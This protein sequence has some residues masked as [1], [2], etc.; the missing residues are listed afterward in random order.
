MIY[1]IEMF[2]A[3]VFRGLQFG[4]L[5][6]RGDSFFKGFGFCSRNGGLICLVDCIFFEFFMIYLCFSKNFLFEFDSF[7]FKQRI[8]GSFP[9]FVRGEMFRYY[10]RLAENWDRIV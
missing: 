7:T 3:G 8:S 5:I 2:L 6:F 4:T 10:K 9:L 1:F